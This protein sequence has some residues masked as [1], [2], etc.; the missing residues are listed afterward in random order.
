MQAIPILISSLALFLS[1]YVAYRAWKFNDIATRRASRETHS[2]M[3]FDIGKMLVDSPELW[4]I[5]DS[6]P[7]AAQKDTSALAVA[8]RD[9]FIIQHLNVFELV[10]DYYK[11]LIKQD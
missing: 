1:G 8:K 9:A 5:Y 11:Y 10:F 6:N 7:L 4:A 3:L 2:K